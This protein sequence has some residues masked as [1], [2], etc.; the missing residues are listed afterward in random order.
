M[1]VNFDIPDEEMNTIKEISDELGLEWEKV[2]QAL[3]TSIMKSVVLVLKSLHACIK[4]VP[5]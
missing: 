2:T 4:E 1:K 3:V 5:K